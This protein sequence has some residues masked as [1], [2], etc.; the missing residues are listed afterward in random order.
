MK[1]DK[2]G[3]VVESRDEADQIMYDL[4]HLSKKGLWPGTDHVEIPR[5]ALLIHRDMF[6]A[7]LSA[8]P[9][10]GHVREAALWGVAKYAMDH[11]GEH[12]HG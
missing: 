10:S 11:I 8:G 9:A 3:V 6:D 2:G 7:A 1:I 5:W 4:E 12:V